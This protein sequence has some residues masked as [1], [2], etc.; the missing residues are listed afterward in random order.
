MAE[1]RLLRNYAALLN[2]HRGW[3]LE[4]DHPGCAKPVPEHAKPNARRGFLHGHE[5]LAAFRENCIELVRLLYADCGQRKIGAAHR[6]KTLRRDVRSHD[7][8]P[9]D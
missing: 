3:R 6:L 1:G 4:E 7:L 2:A 8:R 9:R 5:D